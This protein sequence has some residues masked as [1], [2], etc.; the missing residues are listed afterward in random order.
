MNRFVCACAVTG[1]LWIQSGTEPA[2]AAPVAPAQLLTTELAGIVRLPGHLAEQKLVIG[3]PAAAVPYELSARLDVGAS[4]TSGLLSIEDETAVLATVP[5][6]SGTRAITVPLE[7]AT[8]RDGHVTLTVRLVLTP[9]SP[10]CSLPTAR[11]IDLYRMTLSFQKADGPSAAAPDAWPSELRAVEIHVAPTPS[12]AEATAV[13]MVS[14]RAARAVRGHDVAVTVRPL[15]SI[16]SAP[17][18]AP[19]FSRTVVVSGASKSSVPDEM[20]T[21]ARRQWT[22]AQ[23]GAP[24]ILIRGPKQREGAVRFSQADLGGP[25]S[26]LTL[27]LSGTY[28]PAPPAPGARLMVLMNGRLV[29]SF[30]PERSGRFNVSGAVPPAVIERENMLTLRVPAGAA[31]DDLA[32][33]PFEVAVNPESFIMAERG[34]TLPPGFDRFPQALLPRFVVSFDRVAPEALE[35]A[36]QLIAAMQRTTRAPLRPEVVS[37]E[38]ALHSTKPWLAVVTGEVKAH[39]LGAP[40]DLAPFRLTDRDRRELIRVDGDTPLAALEGFA[41]GERDILLLTERGHRHRLLAL[42]HDLPAQ[43]GWHGVSGNVWLAAEGRPP[44][45]M[46]IGDT[47]LHVGPLLASDRDRNALR[48]ALVVAVLLLLAAVLVWAYP[49]TVRPHPRTARGPRGAPARRQAESRA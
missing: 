23:L 45:G 10:A 11:C 27:H 21:A 30:S 26:G 49:R 47:G 38:D 36:A 5:V 3:A 43:G 15:E 35:A 46:R 18:V 7:R 16:P 22:L 42:A 28:T 17:A 1:L 9:G 6:A 14:A 37:W 39:S 13:L 31:G 4:F 44:F 40:L 19:P 48:D 32:D 12:L 34:Q 20:E 2:F 24:Q 8:V 25:V 29:W 41:R 33:P